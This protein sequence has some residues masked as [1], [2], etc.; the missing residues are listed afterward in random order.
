MKT[1]KRFAVIINPAAG[2]GQTLRKLP[3]LKE[4][5]ARFGSKFDYFITEHPH[6]AT[7]ISDKIHKKYDAVVAFGGDGTANEVMNGLAGTETPLGIIP[8]GTG[9][10]FARS[11]K[12][13]RKI[14]KALQILHDYKTKIIDLGT[15]GQR[16]FLNGVGIGFD[17]YVNLKSKSV[18][19]FKGSLSYLYAVFSSLAFWK[20]IP[21]HIEIDDHTVLRQ[22]SY[23][24]AVGNGWSVGGGLVLTPDAVLDDSAFDICHIADVPLGKIL[25]NFG[26]L[27]T[28]TIGAVREVTLTKA[29]K[30]IIVKSECPL[31]THFDGEF[32]Y[33]LS[34][35]LEIKI[36]PQSAAVIGAW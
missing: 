12:V 2:K 30:N 33:P 31:P 20:S 19:M 13:P 1:K 15:I 17:G 32:Y 28:G 8:I 11:L 35:E 23:L 16:V 36:V 26:R 7:Q 21:M 25:L 27:K 6:H 34:N 3:I 18:T 29:R 4:I 10:D 24:F 9:N 22:S 14:A 5:A